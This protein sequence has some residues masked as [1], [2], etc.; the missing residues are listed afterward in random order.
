MLSKKKQDIAIQIRGCVHTF[1]SARLT[2][3]NAGV[4]P[5]DRY[6]RAE[7]QSKLSR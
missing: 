2:L 3:I 7:R 4:K 5:R 1:A 6:V